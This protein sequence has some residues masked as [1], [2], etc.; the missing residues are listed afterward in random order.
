MSAACPPRP[1]QGGRS[2][3]HFRSTHASAPP[4]L[5]PKRARPARSRAACGLWHAHS[6]RIRRVAACLLRVD[7]LCPSSPLPQPSRLVRPQPARPARPH[8]TSAPSTQPCLRCARSA[9]LDQRSTRAPPCSDPL[10]PPVCPHLFG[11]P[12]DSLKQPCRRS[13]P[14]SSRRRR[15][16]RP[17]AGPATRRSS[18]TTR[19][20]RV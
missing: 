17:S 18:S 15:A 1:A 2:L 12:F 8:H 19:S 5:Q 20:T 4:P 7:H 3:S 9:R 14:S 6:P 13:L 11:R 10:D 16:G